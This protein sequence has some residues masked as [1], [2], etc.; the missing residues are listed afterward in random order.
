MQRA[1]PSALTNRSE[2]DRTLAPVGPENHTFPYLEKPLPM[3][4]PL[5]PGTP[6]PVSGIYR[7]TDG[8]QVVS[9]QGK[10]LPPAAKPGQ[11]YRPVQA[12]RHK[13]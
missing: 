6:A 12:A 2:A 1:L 13:R 5:K 10:P 8:E 3:T 11:V 4:K 9:T 7:R